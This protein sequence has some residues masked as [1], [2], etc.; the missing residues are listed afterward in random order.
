MAEEF[1]SIPY[2]LGRQFLGEFL[3]NPLFQE[4][5]LLYLGLGTSTV[6]MFQ[7]FSAVSK[8]CRGA[9]QVHLLQSFTLEVQYFQVLV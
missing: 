2:G 1:L 9:V 6:A 8:S 3:R 7:S 4:L 5:T